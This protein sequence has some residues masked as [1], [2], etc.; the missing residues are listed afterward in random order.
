M[1]SVSGPSFLFW[2]C[3]DLYLYLLKIYHR[4]SALVV[5]NYLPIYKWATTVLEREPGKLVPAVDLY[6]NKVQLCKKCHVIFTEL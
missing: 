4:M 6:C 1:V 5:L 3:K 2:T